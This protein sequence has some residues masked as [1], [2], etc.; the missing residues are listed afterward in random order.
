M[1]LIAFTGPAGMGKTFQL[2]RREESTLVSAP[3]TDGQKVLAL[4]FMHGSRRRLDDRLRRVPGLRGRFSCMTIDRFAWELCTRWRSLRRVEGLPELAEDQYDATCDAAGAL[5]EK[6]SVRKWVAQTYPHV[7][8][9][10]AQDLTPERLRIIRALEPAVVMHAAAD[11]FQCLA[12]HLRPN[13]AVAW[14]QTRCQP[15]DLQIQRR[16]TQAGL[17]AAA[18]AIR[19]GRAVVAA[20]TLVVRAA[21]GTPPYHQAA[22]TVA[23]AIA[24]NGGT[25]IAVI[26]PSKSGGFATGIVTRVGAGPIGR[27]QNGPYGIRW[28]LSDD[29]FAMQQAGNLNLPENGNFD[30]TIETLSAPGSHP[31]ILMCRDWVARSHKL[32]GDTT[33]LPE[34]VREQLKI[35]FTRYRRFSRGHSSRLMA[36]TVHQAKNREFEG[37]IV[38]WPYTVAGNAEQK[39]RLLYNAVTRAKR[40]CTIVVQNA[41]VLQ[42]P[43]FAAPLAI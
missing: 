26:T 15:L 43:P 38:L 41:S 28:E 39:R 36:M 31:A 13:P 22:A 33:F 24:W 11:E 9:D 29:E 3:L 16:T 34:L 10:E 25:E 40:W 35:C 1:S 2:M 42:Q 14:M 17:I 19:A 6:L 37:V 30:A 12:A 8:I 32:T 4:T 23:N 27:Q 21:P 20:H 7:L 5:M 18:H